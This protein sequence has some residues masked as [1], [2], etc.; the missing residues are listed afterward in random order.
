[1][2]WKRFKIFTENQC[3]IFNNSDYTRNVFQPDGILQ[4]LD[5][6]DIDF[7]YENS[8]NEFVPDAEEADTSEIAYD[9]CDS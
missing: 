7:S 8:G 6:S 5:N 4:F 3:I 2:F 1:M 9:P